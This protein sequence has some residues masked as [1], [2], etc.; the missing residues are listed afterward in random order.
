MD[1]TEIHIALLS[2]PTMGTE[3]CP[4]VGGDLGPGGQYEK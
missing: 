3:H 4:H 1:A 2:N